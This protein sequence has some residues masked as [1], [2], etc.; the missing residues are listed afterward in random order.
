MRPMQSENGHQSDDNFIDDP[1]ALEAAEAAVR[2]VDRTSA[3]PIAPLPEGWT[4]LVHSL[5]YDKQKLGALAY[6][7]AAAGIPTDW[8][9]FEPEE[10]PLL[11]LFSLHETKFSVRVP[12]E[13]SEAAKQILGEVTV[14]FAGGTEA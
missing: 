6:G 5:P 7:L 13:D 2:Q 12:K 3:R 9:P 14:R 11:R 8:E 1:A 10:A 4:T